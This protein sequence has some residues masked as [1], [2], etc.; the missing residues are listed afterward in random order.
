MRRIVIRTV[1]DE[2]VDGEACAEARSVFL[3]DNMDFSGNAASLGV[4]HAV[5]GCVREIVNHDATKRCLTEFPTQ[6][7]GH[8]G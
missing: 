5:P 7:V 2:R 6:L 1:G 8:F 3:E 4:V